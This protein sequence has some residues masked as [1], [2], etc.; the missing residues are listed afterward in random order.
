MKNREL[1]DAQVQQDSLQ[2]TR[3]SPSPFGIKYRGKKTDPFPG[4]PSMAQKSVET[5]S[6]NPSSFTTPQSYLLRLL[7][8]PTP[9]PCLRTEE[10]AQHFNYLF[11]YSLQTTHTGFFPCLQT[12]ELDHILVNFSSRF[13]IFATHPVS[14]DCD[15]RAIFLFRKER[16]QHINRY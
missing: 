14:N 4:W 7:V 8:S 15:I 5:L 1:V 2:T 13:G 10:N 3:K 16:L 9:K 12:R 6:T 11:R